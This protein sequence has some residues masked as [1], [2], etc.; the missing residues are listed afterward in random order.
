MTVTAMTPSQ[1]VGVVGAGTMGAGIA[2]VAAKYGHTVK[3]YDQSPVS[4]K[5]GL[6]SVTEGLEKLQSRDRISTQEIKT[7]LANIESCDALE[8]LAQCDLVIEAIVEDLACKQALFVQLESIC[9]ND[10]IFATNTSSISITAIASV[11]QRPEQLAGMHFFNPA[12]VMKLIEVVSGLAT[13]ADVATIIANTASAWGKKTVQVKSSPGFIVNRVA[14]PFYAETLR[15]LEEEVASQATLDAI[16]REGGGFRMGP[17]ELMDLIG[18]DVNYAVTESVFHAFYQDPRFLPS[19]LQ[20][21]RVDGGF[22]GRKSGRGFYIYGD[23]S[24]L[25]EPQTRESALCPRSVEILGDLGIAAGLMQKLEEAGLQKKHADGPGLIL[26]GDATLALTDGRTA[27]RRSYEEGIENLVLFDLQGDYAQHTHIAIAASLSASKI[28]LEQAIGFFTR[29]GKSVSVL[30][31]TPGLCLMRIVCML[32]NEGADAVNQGVCNVTAVDRA[33]RYGL[34]YPQGPMAW[35]DKMGL[36]NVCTVL[37]NL[38]KSYGL[39]RYRTSL[40]LQQL[41]HVGKK[42]YD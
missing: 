5:K 11:L 27:T 40:L 19:L 38:Q 26:C 28:A 3:L 32:A 35:A 29:L 17:L 41:S 10:T 4:V 24:V 31:D 37:G 8:Q 13:S 22:L 6:S 7:L 23:K 39:D 21:E 34:N 30:K 18:L 36:Q 42:L 1:I 12:P 9:S 16:V 20:K 14:R 15:L 33:M 25:S 2:Q